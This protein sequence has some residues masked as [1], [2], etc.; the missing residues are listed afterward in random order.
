MRAVD[1]DALLHHRCQG[2]FGLFRR[3]KLDCKHEPQSPDIH[4]AFVICSQMC[5]FLAKIRTDFCYM[6]EKT[7]LFNRVHDSN[8]D[9]ACQRTA[10]ERGPVHTGV[11]CLCN[12]LLAKECAQRQTSRERFRKSRYVRLNA[13]MLIG[14]PFAGATKSGLN[15]IDHQQCTG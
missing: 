8:C 10:A 11:K 13:V 7:F 9:S 15:F 2:F 5:Q 3:R 4:N 6:S 14:E 12:C 1:K